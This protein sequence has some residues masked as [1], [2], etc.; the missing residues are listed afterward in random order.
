MLARPRRGD[1]QVE[2]PRSGG[3]VPVQDDNQ[4]RD[5]DRKTRDVDDHVL[6]LPPPPGDGCPGLPDPAGRPNRSS[7]G[8]APSSPTRPCCLV[9]EEGATGGGSGAVRSSELSLGMQK[10]TSRL[11]RQLA[12]TD[13]PTPIYRPVRRRFRRPVLP[14]ASVRDQSGEADP[15][16]LVLRVSTR[17]D[18]GCHRLGA[19]APAAARVARQ[20]ESEVH[21]RDGVFRQEVPLDL[22]QAV[23]ACESQAVVVG[24]EHDGLDHLRAKLLR[25]RARGDELVLVEGSRPVS[26]VTA[27]DLARDDRLTLWVRDDSVLVFGEHAATV[28]RENLS[29]VTLEATWRLT[30]LDLSGQ[31]DPGGPHRV[32][33]VAFGN[34]V[35]MSTEVAV[36]LVSDWERWCGATYMG[37]RTWRWRRLRMRSSASKARTIETD[38][39][40]RRVRT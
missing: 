14:C 35:L 21:E 2:W 15:Y 27:A 34:R 30:R 24:F 17:F 12:P 22:D 36:A 23:L 26:A 20:V 4:L 33:L 1:P 19:F 31:H 16:D 6:V 7:H 10:A 37:S 5:V 40:W 32:Q 25:L 11:W 3:V 29:D 38:F 18:G 8:T 9:A 39:A 28:V 13:L